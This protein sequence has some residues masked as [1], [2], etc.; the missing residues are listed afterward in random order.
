MASAGIFFAESILS[1]MGLE[2]EVIAEGAAYMRILFVG[3]VF[4]VFRMVAEAIMQSSGDAVTPMRVAVM[5]RV[6]HIALCPFLVFGWWLFPRLGVSGAAL[7][8]VI[9]QSLGL[10]IGLW[11]L[12]TGRSRLRLTLSNF[13]FDLNIIWRM[14]KIGIPAAVMGVQFNLVQFALMWFMVPFGTLAVA[15]HTLTQRIEM[16]L[17]MPG[18]GFGIAAG[19]LAGQNMGARQ[20]ER[21]ERSGWLAIGFVEGILAI[22]SVVILLWADGLVHIFSS[23]PGLVELG[24]TFLRIAAAGYLVIG[25][26]VVGMQFLS[27]V[28]DTL[29][30]MLI[31]L[32]IAWGVQLPLAYLLPRVTDLG[33]YGIRWAMVIGVLVGAT[34]FITYF[35]MGRWKRKEV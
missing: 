27:G 17:F 14:V 9:S 29:P 10:G 31:S 15:G 24:G 4:M 16:I 30:P 26:F 11:F 22:C 12:F 25:F 21:A 6:V 23:D 19:V 35:R 2:A 3:S 5:F 32:L 34:A 33:V 13:R 1:L 7:T 8:N 18:M 28:G 20:P